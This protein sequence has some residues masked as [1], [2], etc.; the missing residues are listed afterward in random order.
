MWKTLLVYLAWADI[1]ELFILSS[2]CIILLLGNYCSHAL[3]FADD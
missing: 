1:D 3:S 2:A